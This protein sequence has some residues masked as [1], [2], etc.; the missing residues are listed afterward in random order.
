MKNFIMAACAVTLAAPYAVVSGAGCLVGHLFGVAMSD[1]D[2]GDDVTLQLDG[3]Y[4]LKK[5]AG[6]TPAAGAQIYWDDTNKV[7]TTAAT[8]GNF[9]IGAAIAAAVAG[10]ATVQVRL[11]GISV[12][13]T[14]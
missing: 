14:A 2:E 10:D 7:A 1:A 6:D 3:A 4:A 11:N 8:A 5:H 13:A 12:V 9:L